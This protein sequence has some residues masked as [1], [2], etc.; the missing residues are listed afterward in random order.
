MLI[1]IWFKNDQFV[2]LMLSLSFTS[3]SSL[4][5]CNVPSLAIVIFTSQGTEEWTI[6]WQQGALRPYIGYDS[7]LQ[8]HYAKTGSHTFQKYMLDGF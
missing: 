2:E 4:Y 8:R 6:V 5:C 3:T 1:I 7:S